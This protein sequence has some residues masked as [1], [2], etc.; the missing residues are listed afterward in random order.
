MDTVADEKT[1]LKL[2]S[3]SLHVV[4]VFTCECGESPLVI[5]GLSEVR[6]CPTCQSRFM[7][8]EITHQPLANGQFETNVQI[9]RLSALAVGRPAFEIVRR[10]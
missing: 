2:H 5:T 7:I 10:S 9:G 8:A 3:A 4:A 6:T 1:T